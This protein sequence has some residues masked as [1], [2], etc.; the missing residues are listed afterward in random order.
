ME[1][2]NDGLFIWTERATVPGHVDVQV[3]PSRLPLLSQWAETLS[4]STEIIHE[5][6]QADIEALFTLNNDIQSSSSGFFDSYAD[7]DQMQAFLRQLQVTY[8]TLVSVV[9]VG[10]T[11]EGRDIT[12]VV[13]S[14]GQKQN[15]SKIVINGCQHAR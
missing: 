5:D 2:M 3:A 12:G 13:I 1:E 6:L 10:K 11:L 9:Q 4:I 8:P 14:H 15:K 7:Y